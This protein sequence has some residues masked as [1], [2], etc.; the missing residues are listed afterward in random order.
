MATLYVGRAGWSRPAAGA[1]RI[2]TH[3]ILRLAAFA[4]PIYAAGQPVVA[5]VPAIFS[6]H[7]GV[8]LPVL[9][10]VLLIGQAV[11]A[12]LDPLIGSLSDRTRTR[13]G[14][15][16]PWIAGGGVLFILGTGM[17]F[18]PPARIP[19]AWLT[20]AIL[21]YF[22]GTSAIVTPLFAWSGEVSRD[23]DERT[24]IAG[25]FT[26]ASSIALVLALSLPAV[27]DQVRPGDGPLRLTLFGVLTLGTALPALVLTL[28][29][30]PDRVPAALPERTGLRAALSAVFANPMLLRVLAADAAVT[31]G[32]GIRTALALFIVTI[33]F[34]RPEWAAGLFLFQYSFGMLAGPIWQ[35]IGVALGKTR[36]AVL[37]EA[38][39]AAINFGLLFLT[40]DRWPLMLALALAQGLTQGSGN[41]MLRAM[42]ADVADHYRTATG[43][44][45]AGL[46][47]SVFGLSIK[48]G[49]ALA[50]G[51]ALPLV[52]WFG[53]DPKAAHNAP[54]AL[55][56]LLAVFALGPALA[57]SA[58]AFIVAGFP[59]DARRQSEIRRQLEARDAVAA[60]ALTPAE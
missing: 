31:T 57:H 27:A 51:I 33:Y 15:R 22:V 9:G 40:P 38:L 35:R 47:F 49:G 32:Q 29:A 26:L 20:T 16:R 10:L 23:Y 21:F 3:R 53:F 42:V 50:A 5:F 43:E 17:L 37:A 39:Q 2:P 19:V 48:L 44:D 13:F 7:Y 46:Y 28:T 60:A 11:N 55:Q 52:A 18:F 34:D 8:T 4:V 58:A 59:L 12:F 56:G 24:R 54:Q 1:G 45:H 30:L 41:L 36:A 25:L 6:R 14:R